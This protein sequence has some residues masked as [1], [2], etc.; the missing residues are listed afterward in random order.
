MDWG[1]VAF[2]DCSEEMH[3][4]EWL[5]TSYHMRKFRTLTE[6]VLE[7]KEHVEKPYRSKRHKKHPDLPKKLLTTFL[8]FFKE[9]WSLYSQKYLKLSNLQL[10]NLLSEEYKELPEQIKLKY[11]HDFQ[12]EKQEFE[13]KLAQFKT[14]NS[15][16]FQNSKKSDSGAARCSPE[17][18]HGGDWQRLAVSPPNQK[19]LYEQQAEELQKQYRM[20]LDHWL[21]ILSSEEYAA[22]REVTH[23]KHKNMSMRGG[24]DPK[25]RQTE[26]Q[27]LSPR[28]LQEGLGQES[29]LQTP[30][31]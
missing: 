28:S 10:T 15:D 23:T 3:K 22:Y 7:A 24:P 18:V 25:I 1:K 27:S 13:E 2:E 4:L 19:E 14:E 11:F 31:T 16:L 9:N 29:K 26:L 20:D 6:L 30:E 17:G 8:C 21:K 12:K 5:E